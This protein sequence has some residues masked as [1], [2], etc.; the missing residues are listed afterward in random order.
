[1]TRWRVAGSA[2]RTA[3]GAKVI[4]R[5]VLDRRRLLRAAADTADRRGF[6]LQQTLATVQPL[7]TSPTTFFFSAR[8][9]SK[10]V[11][12]NGDMPLISRIGFTATPGWSM[13]NRMNVMPSC[14]GAFGSV[15]TRQKIQSA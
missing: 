9:L 11:S 5:D 13:S 6:V 14:F 2:M 7:F 1:M 8:A 12:Q 15:R 4:F 3:V 10:N